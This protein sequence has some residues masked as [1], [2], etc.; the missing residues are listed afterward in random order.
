MGWLWGR[1]GAKGGWGRGA[2]G[3]RVGRGEGGGAAGKSDETG[4]GERVQG[5]GEGRRGPKG[6]D[7]GGRGNT[8]WGEGGDKSRPFQF[9]GTCTVHDPV[10][11]TSSSRHRERRELVATFGVPFRAL[12]VVV[13]LVLVVKH[14]TKQRDQRRYLVGASAAG[15]RLLLFAADVLPPL[16]RGSRSF[17][18]RGEDGGRRPLRSHRRR[19]WPCGW[20]VATR[21]RTLRRPR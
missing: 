18:A 2:G 15:R 4:R 21:A 6:W 13:G 19:P 17:C 5:M 10:Y 3:G 16:R 20:A 7:E 14:G 11:G 9:I 8:G 12:R 1:V